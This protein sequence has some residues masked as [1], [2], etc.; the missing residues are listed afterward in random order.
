MKKEIIKILENSFQM[1][2]PGDALETIPVK[3]DKSTDAIK[4]GRSVWCGDW[5]DDNYYR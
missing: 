4:Y 5:R 3:K 2:L 1:T